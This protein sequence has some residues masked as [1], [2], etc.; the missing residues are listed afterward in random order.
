MDF[1]FWAALLLAMIVIVVLIKSKKKTKQISSL[2]CR[3]LYEDQRATTTNTAPD[4]EAQVVGGPELG[5]E[6]GA[7]AQVP[8]P[9]VMPRKMEFPDR[10]EAAMNAMMQPTSDQDFSEVAFPILTPSEWGY[11]P[12]GRERLIAVLDNVKRLEMKGTGRVASHGLS[13]S[14]PIVKGVRYRIGSA[15]IAAEKRMH[16]TDTG[17]MI[18]TD[19]AV[20]FEGK[21]RNERMTWT[22]I[23]NVELRRDG[24]VI[25]KRTG[26]PRT[27]EFAREEP[28]VAAILLLL[29]RSHE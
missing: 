4:R 9:P 18:V 20:S 11:R 17:R 10:V 25:A 27:F 2:P 7:R 23:A 19:K 8:A 16:V 28:E 22:Q 5:P 6:M 3:P 13:V 29:E 1:G 15:R 24:V 21:A 26:S 14:I 12:V